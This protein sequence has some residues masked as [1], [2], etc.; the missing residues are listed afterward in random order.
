MCLD[1]KNKLSFE[2]RRESVVLSYRGLNNNGPDDELD[3]PAEYRNMEIMTHE[4]EDLEFAIQEARKYLAEQRAKKYASTEDQKKMLKR[5]WK[6]RYIQLKRDVSNRGGGVFR[7]GE[8]FQVEENYGGIDFERKDLV[9]KDYDPKQD[10][11]LP[12]KNDA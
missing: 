10:T 11:T 4:L 7:A 6:G 5:D 9:S 12:G 3:N 2:V 1:G 8:V